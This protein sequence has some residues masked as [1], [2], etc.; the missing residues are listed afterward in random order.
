MIMM[1]ITM[2]GMTIMTITPGCKVGGSL[3]APLSTRR[4]G[5]TSLQRCMSMMMMM[6]VVVMVAVVKKDSGLFQDEPKMQAG[7]AIDNVMIA[8]TSKKK[9][10]SCEDKY[11]ILSSTSVHQHILKKLSLSQFLIFF[12]M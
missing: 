3:R 8:V 7:D 9:Q 1:A 12:K 6:V 11:M 4:G 5:R 2:T 10:F